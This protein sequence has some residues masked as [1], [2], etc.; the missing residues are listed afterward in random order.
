MYCRSMESGS[1]VWVCVNILQQ[2]HSVFLSRIMTTPWERIAS[3]I[4]M[5]I[6]VLGNRRQRGEC[7]QLWK[8][9]I[10]SIHYSNIHRT[11]FLVLCVL[12]LFATYCYSLFS[13][14]YFLFGVW[15]FYQNFYN[16]LLAALW[17]PS[18][19]SNVGLYQTHYQISTSFEITE[20]NE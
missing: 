20:E 13:R 6:G 4:F 18:L 15:I 3:V 11:L 2:L 7:T 17:C 10:P 12:H 8:G 14:H 1:C 9:T 5:L 16:F 19:F